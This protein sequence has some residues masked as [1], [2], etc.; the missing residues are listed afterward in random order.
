MMTVRRCRASLVCHKVSIGD[1]CLIIHKDAYKGEGQWKGKM[2]LRAIVGSW[3][4][5][6]S[7]VP[8]GERYLTFSFHL[9]FQGLSDGQ[10]FNPVG[11]Q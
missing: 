1:L 10:A 6:F 3:R 5:L 4:E 11:C 9:F 2:I 8:G 7:A